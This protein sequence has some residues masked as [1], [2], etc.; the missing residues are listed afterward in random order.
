VI[1]SLLVDAKINTE[2]PLKL[3][4]VKCLNSTEKRVLEKD[5]KYMRGLSQLYRLT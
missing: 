5:D 4:K 2:E 3:S 1:S